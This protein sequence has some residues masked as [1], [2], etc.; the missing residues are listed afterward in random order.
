VRLWIETSATYPGTYASLGCGSYPVFAP[1]AQLRDRCG[2]CHTQ[3]V[4][5]QRGRRSAIVFPGAQ[6]ERSERAFNLS[7]PEKSY[8][9][10]A[11]LAKQ[12]GGLGL[13]KEAVFKN[14]DDPV[15][16][17]T[18]AAVRDAHNRLMAGKRFDM[19]GFRP[20]EHYIR[21]MQR[22]GFLPKDLKPTDPIDCYAVDRAYWDSF[23]WQAQTG[24]SAEAGGR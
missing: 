7:R 3:E 10:L 11:P 20:N 24:A 9:L 23:N 16:Q 19:P 12:S 2:N 22:F 21:E 13:C 8:A 18:L 6:G 4:N 1:M 14:T 17:A 15:Y 5:D